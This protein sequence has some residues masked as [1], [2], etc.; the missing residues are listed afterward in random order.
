MSERKAFKDLLDTA[1][2]KEGGLGGMLEKVA[3]IPS[4]PDA[5]AADES[6]KEEAPAKN[7]SVTPEQRR[8]VDDARNASRGRGH[9]KESRKMVA[10]HVPE[11]IIERVDTL[12]YALGR[13]KNDLYNEALE[14]LVRKYRNV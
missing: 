5:V 4:S 13:S 14:L 12:C 1:L 7:S 6:V 10:F 9:K 8:A 2:A 3:P 11:T